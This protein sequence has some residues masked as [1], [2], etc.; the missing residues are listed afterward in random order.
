MPLVLLLDSDCLPAV[1]CVIYLLLPVNYFAAAC[2]VNFPNRDYRFGFI[3]G[4]PP[5]RTDWELY[6]LMI[7]NLK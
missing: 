3:I 4:K 5:D 2:F 7:W 6:F 1:F